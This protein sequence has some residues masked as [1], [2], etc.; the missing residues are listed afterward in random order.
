[1]RCVLQRVSNCRLYI[2][3]NLYS[4]ISYGLLVY[5]G[6]ETTDSTEDAEFISNKILHLRCFHDENQKMNLSVSDI[7]AQIMVVSQ[8]TLCADLRKGRRPSFNNSALPS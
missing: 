7:N 3:K 8:F 6:V 1:M 2:E 4:E 5:A